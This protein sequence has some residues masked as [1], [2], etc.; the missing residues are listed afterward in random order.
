MS[1]TASEASR[2]AVWISILTEPDRG[3]P[4]RARSSAGV[5]VATILPL[6]MIFTAREIS[7]RITH[8]N[9]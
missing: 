3:M 6:L 1:N 8:R 2:S 7:Y 9:L 4:E 5:P